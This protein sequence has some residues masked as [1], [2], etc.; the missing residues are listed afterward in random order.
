MFQLLVLDDEVMIGELVCA[1]LRSVKI[2]AFGCATLQEASRFLDSFSQKGAQVDLL[3]VD[4]GL[5]GGMNGR[6]AARYLLEL[7]PGMKTLYMTG[8]SEDSREKTMEHVL[9]KPFQMDELMQKIREM[10][11]V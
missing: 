6:D 10:F 1:Y 4:F 9:Y 5:E 3:I 11:P 2:S 8:R 7:N